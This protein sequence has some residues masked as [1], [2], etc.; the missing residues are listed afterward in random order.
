MSPLSYF[1][2]DVGVFAGMRAL[3]GSIVDLDARLPSSP[4]KKS[5]LLGGFDETDWAISGPFWPELQKLA[6]QS[7]DDIIILAVLDPDQLSSFH[8]EFGY[9]KWATIPTTATENDYWKIIDATPNEE[10]CDSV[11]IGGGVIVLT[12]PSG[13]WA[14]WCERECEIMVLGSSMPELKGVLKDFDWVKEFSYNQNAVWLSF[15]QEL[16]KNFQPHVDAGASG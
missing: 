8:Q 15:V 10:N 4:F 1:I 5:W 14:I 3:V 2:T 16:R 13:K 11:L 7:E 6:S 12:V 9:Y